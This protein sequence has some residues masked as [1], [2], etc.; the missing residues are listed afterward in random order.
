MSP[1]PRPVL[2]GERYGRLTVTKTRQP[3]EVFV[4]VRCDC[5]T[6]TTVRFLDLGR[7][8]NSCGC[9]R[10]ETNTNR[11]K[12][13]MCGTSIYWTWSDMV[14]RCTNPRHKRYADY[15]AR[16]ITVCERWRDFANFLADMGDRPPGLELDRIDN[17][18]GYEP[19]NCRWADRST[20]MKNRRPAAYAGT[21]RDD[22][23]GRFL[24][25]GDAR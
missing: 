21:V 1:R 12:H 17:D 23:T 5:G 19:S 4:S 8:T 14:A 10:N 15:G 2:E 25:K 11:T 7:C 16:G 13:G 24:P 6:E 20:Q 3:G 22:L 18:R 9:L